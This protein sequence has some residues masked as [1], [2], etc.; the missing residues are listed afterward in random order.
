MIDVESKDSME[1]VKRHIRVDIDDDDVS[2]KRM[3]RVAQNMLMSQIGQNEKYR[4]FYLQEEVDEI[5][6]LAT[7]FLTD[8]YYKT[9]SATT[10]L[11]FH[12]VPMSVQAMVLSLKASYHVYVTKKDAG[13]G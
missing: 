5:F 2:I 10:S 4:A 7:L 3:V 1:E 6:D 12:T 9:R 8:H 13:D 11:S